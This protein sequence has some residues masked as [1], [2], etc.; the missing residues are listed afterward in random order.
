MSGQRSGHVMTLAKP[1]ELLASL[2]ETARMQTRIANLEIDAEDGILAL[3]VASAYRSFVSSDWTYE[4][5]LSHI[6]DETAA[7]NIL[8]WECGDGG[9]AYRLDV[10]RGLTDDQGHRAISGTILPG[11]GQ[12]HL[13][14]YAALTMAAQ[15]DDEVLPAKDE[16]HLVIEIEAGL[17]QVR[18]VQLNDPASPDLGAFEGPHFRIELAPG[19]AEGWSGVAWETVSASSATGQES[20]P[21]GGLGG[22]FSRLWGR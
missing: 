4:Q 8:A 3:V 2:A 22:L 10:V 1:L 11:G 7:R 9:N 16:A 19:E 5:I 12:L 13:C 14:S 6:A 15:F 17:T 18:L 21:R 20:K